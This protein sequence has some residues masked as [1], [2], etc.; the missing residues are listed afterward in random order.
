MNP[1]EAVLGLACVQNPA[2][3]GNTGDTTP[4]VDPGYL[5]V[6]PGN[7]AVRQG[8]HGEVPEHWRPDQGIH[9]YQ[10]GEDDSGRSGQRQQ[11]CKYG[12]DG[13][14]VMFHGSFNGRELRDV[15]TDLPVKSE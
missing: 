8:L 6:N 3:K 5:L 11:F 14:G 4:G 13:L 12:A 10:V 9:P 15:K 1:D 2:T 7:D